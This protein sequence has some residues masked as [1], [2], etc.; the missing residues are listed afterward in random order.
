[1]LLKEGW[2]AEFQRRCVHWK[3]TTFF[4][5]ATHYA[6]MILSI[7]GSAICLRKLGDTCCGDCFSLSLNP[8]FKVHLIGSICL[9]IKLNTRM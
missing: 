8:K 7:A 9:A 5:H 4:L 2:L 1:M 3:A 6:E